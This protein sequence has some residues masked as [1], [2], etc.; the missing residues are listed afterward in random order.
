MMSPGTRAD[1]GTRDSLPERKA[2]ASSGEY[3]RNACEE[4]ANVRFL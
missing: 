1:A 3:S 4:S 2:K